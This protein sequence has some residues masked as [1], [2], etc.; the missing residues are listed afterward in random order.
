MCSVSERLVCNVR[1]IA[2]RILR[3]TR[4]SLSLDAPSNDVNVIQLRF[5]YKE[6][7][8]RDRPGSARFVTG[9]GR[10]LVVMG[11][12]IGFSGAAS[13]GCGRSR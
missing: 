2:V 11:L 10:I 12:G 13:C 5:D 7:R 1:T 9:F 6:P 4:H 8:L 3:P